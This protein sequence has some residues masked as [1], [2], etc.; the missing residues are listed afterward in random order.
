M[1]NVRNQKKIQIGV[2]VNNKMKKTATVEVERLVQHKI[3]KR[4]FKR[5][6][7][8]KAH[9]E[10]QLCQIGDKVKIMETRPISKT[11]T[12]R[13]VEIVEKAK[14]KLESIPE[15]EGTDIGGRV[16]KEKKVKT[17]EASV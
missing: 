2:V 17:T 3:Y 15:I 10:G 16:V 4:Y 6:S 9:D 5:T 14:A 7:V 12:W 8:F 13:V 1:E 11:K